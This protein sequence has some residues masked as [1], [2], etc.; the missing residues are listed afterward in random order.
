MFPASEAKLFHGI[1]H[2]NKI[3]IFHTI[4]GSQQCQNYSKP[5]VGNESLEQKQKERMARGLP[6]KLPI[7]GVEKVIVVASGKGGV[8]KS[9]AAVNLALGIA[10]VNKSKTVGILDAD[11]FGPSIPRMMNLK[12]PVYVD[13][14]D[15]ME[16]LINFGVKCMSMGF[17]VEENAPVVW[18]GM[19]VMQAIQRMLRQVAW[20]PLDYLVIDMPPGT[21]DTQLSISQNIPVDGAVIISTPQ[22]IA[23]L[24][25][26]KGVEMFN[27]VNVPILGLVQN[28]SMHICSNCGHTEHIFGEDGAKDM[29]DEIGVD[30]LGDILLHIDIRKTADSGQPIVLSKPDSPQ[31]KVYKDI[32][33][34]ICQKIV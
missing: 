18:R 31:A 23:L 32:A 6:K 2:L 11:V 26:R 20:G 17:L 33:Q 30:L 16:P 28:M 5:P 34:K 19:M 21:G 10:A 22:D 7:A 1:K 12:G 9:T 14:K 25:A 29:A 24:D 4:F 27:K 15:R 3:R 13:S 8:G